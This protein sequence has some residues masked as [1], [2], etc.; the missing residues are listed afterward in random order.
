MA[1]S[2][3]RLVLVRLHRKYC[4]LDP[5]TQLS[6]VPYLTLVGN[7]LVTAIVIQPTIRKWESARLEATQNITSVVH[8]KDDPSRCR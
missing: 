7:Y 2:W 6:K 1:D 5:Q 4:V 8:L 3:Y